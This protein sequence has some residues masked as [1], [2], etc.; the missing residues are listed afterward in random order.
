VTYTYTPRTLAAI[1]E[2]PTWAAIL[3]GFAGLGFAGTRAKRK[4][5]GSIGVSTTH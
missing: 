4:G 2:P 1:P 5:R 3:V